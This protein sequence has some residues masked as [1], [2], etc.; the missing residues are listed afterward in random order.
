MFPELSVDEVMPHYEDFC[1]GFLRASARHILHRTQRAIEFCEK[2]E[3]LN[4]SSKKCLVFSGGCA[5]ND[6]LFTA[7]S[8]MAEQ[9]GYQT[10]RPLKQHCTD[11][12]LMIAWNGVEHFLANKGIETNF[13][14][15]EALPKAKFG[16]DWRMEVS[17]ESLACK[18][19]KVPVMVN[20]T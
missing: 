2:R 9:F 20:K 3:L 12:G 11:N 10:I 1:S 16:T 8:Q 18:W 14:V 4:T 19:V 17:G 15:I 7:L 6:F 5:A 13:D